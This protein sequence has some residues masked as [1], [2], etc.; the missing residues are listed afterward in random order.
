MWGG[1]PYL[2]VGSMWQVDS[3]LKESKKIHSQRSTAV[4]I[5][6]QIDQLHVRSRM[7]AYLRSRALEHVGLS[8]RGVVTCNII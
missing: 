1:M 6:M 7:R 4:R 2:V 5:C 3:W 8:E